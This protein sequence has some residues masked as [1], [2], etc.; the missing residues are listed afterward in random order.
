[1]KNNLKK[2]TIKNLLFVLTESLKMLHPFMPFITE[3][4]WA[5]LPF[6]KNLLIIEKW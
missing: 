5:K 4:I 6:T 3:E 2:T 1:V